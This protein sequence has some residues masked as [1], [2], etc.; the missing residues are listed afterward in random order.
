MAPWYKHPW[1]WLLMSGPALVLV[2]GAI[3]TWMAFKS[4]DG[5]V[6]EDYYKQGLGINKVLA[7]E[8]AAKARGIAA[9]VEVTPEKLRVLLRG[10]TPEVIFV[11]MA[12]A[13]RAG[14]DQRLRMTR[15][16]DGAYEAALPPLP[17]G[18]WRVA[19]ED[20]RSTWRVALNEADDAGPHPVH[21]RMSFWASEIFEPRSTRFTAQGRKLLGEVAAKA[22]S[23]DLEVL[24]AVD[25]GDLSAPRAAALRDF[26]LR[27]GLEEGRVY[28]EAHKTGRARVELEI[29][30]SQ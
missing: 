3:T 8:D 9:T 17:A 26:L 12:H 16:A 20:A 2:A 22:R 1:P 13:T 27:A 30:G 6:A 4:S 29:I 23:I 21:E 18:R 10:E 19:I 14:H 7:R 24:I 25:Y 15:A 28:S 5:L 11:H